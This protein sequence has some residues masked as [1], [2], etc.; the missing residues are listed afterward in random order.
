MK[1]DLDQ[2]PEASDVTVGNTQ[3]ALLQGWPLS[4]KGPPLPRET[5]F[6]PRVAGQIYLFQVF[7]AYLIKKGVINVDL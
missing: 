5:D 2:K 4:N 3:V 6:D 1:V 7:L